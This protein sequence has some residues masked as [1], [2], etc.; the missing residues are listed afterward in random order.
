MWNRYY[1]TVS[2]IALLPPTARSSD[3]VHSL[4][5]RML[6]GMM[7]PETVGCEVLYGSLRDPED[8][9]R[10]GPQLKPPAGS[11][12]CVLALSSSFFGL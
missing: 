6:A 11:V 1:L 4:L 7:P 9:P 2:A 8:V 3:R 12:T 5:A 10:A